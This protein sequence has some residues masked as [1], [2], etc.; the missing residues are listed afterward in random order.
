M[1][2]V[3]AVHKE[4]LL[5]LA[6]RVLRLNDEPSYRDQLR[7]RM[8]IDESGSKSIPFGIAKDRLDALFLCAG[9]QF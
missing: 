9:R 3:P 1:T 6:R 2:H 7:L 4:I 5:G 8:H